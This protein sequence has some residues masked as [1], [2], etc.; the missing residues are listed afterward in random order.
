MDEGFEFSQMV[1]DDI[2]AH[3]LADWE[4]IGEFSSALLMAY[5]PPTASLEE[6]SEI[7]CMVMQHH[8]NNPSEVG[9]D[10]LTCFDLMAG[11]RCLLHVEAAFPGS[12][13]RFAESLKTA[14]SVSYHLRMA[15]RAVGV[16]AKSGLQSAEGRKAMPIYSDACYGLTRVVGAERAAY[17]MSYSDAPVPPNVRKK[18]EEL[19]KIA[20]ESPVRLRFVDGV[21]YMPQ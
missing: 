17:L 5:C 12:K 6:V 20:V 11:A 1:I 9:R 4:S 2:A 7:L 3:E 19:T 15:G 18:V 10:F 8:M 21:P 16:M 13:D 14:V